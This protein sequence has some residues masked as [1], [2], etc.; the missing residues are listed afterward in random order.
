MKIELQEITIR[1]LFAGYENDDEQGVR[2]YGGKLDIRPPYQREFVYKPEQQQEVIRTVSRGFP[3]NV[4]YWSR[5]TD[6]TFEILDG[7]QR[8][9]SICEYLE[10]NFS[11]LFDGEKDKL[12]FHNLTADKQ[13]KIL[14]YKL[15]VYVCSGEPSEK[16]DW[17]R[18]INIAGEKLTDQE[19]R[20]AVFAGKFVSAAKKKF[21]KT[22]CVGYLISQDYWK[23]ATIRQELLQTAI[24]WAN[25]GDVAGY[26][27]DHQDDE[28]ADALWNHFQAVIDWI[29]TTFVK[30]R[31]AMKLVDWGKLYRLYGDQ[32]VDAEAM[33]KRVKTLMEDAEVDCK[34]G[35]YTYVFDGEEKHLNLRAFSPIT[36]QTI[37][38]RQNG[39]CNNPKCKH[40]G[41]VFTLEEMEADHIIPWSRGGKTIDEN[42]QMLCRE[43]NRE[44]SDK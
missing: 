12:K 2:A 10:N 41:K 31:A 38:E 17:F 15:M 9:L 28:N 27:S 22:N 30:K 13:A 34:Q 42:C 19:L 29:S 21:S 37:Y 14:D 11:V 7:Q 44:K 24:E 36:K 32:K 40:K 8:T 25:N 16:L 39:R 20:N 4:M 23:G 1:D 3:L 35:I 18:T 6:G 33:E 26:M 5:H 43:C